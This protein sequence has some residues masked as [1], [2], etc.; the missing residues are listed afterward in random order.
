M[1]RNCAPCEG[2]DGHPL[3][4]AD[5]YSVGTAAP[6]SRRPWHTAFAPPARP[7]R[8]SEAVS[9]AHPTGNEGATNRQRRG[10]QVQRQWRTMTDDGRQ[11]MT[12]TTAPGG[13]TW[14]ET[15]RGP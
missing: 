11:L 4:D 12:M 6:R 15:P 9:K 10:I 8:R 2:C 1:R 7:R 14:G 3:A 5:G 13:W